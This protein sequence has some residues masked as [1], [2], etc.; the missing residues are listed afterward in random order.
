LIRL[1]L[2]LLTVEVRLEQLPMLSL[3]LGPLVS[4]LVSQ[5]V[6]VMLS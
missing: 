5:L 6:G 4:Q 1:D 3:L 2:R